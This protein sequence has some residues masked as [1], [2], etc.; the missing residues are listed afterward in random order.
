MLLH[1][2][3]FATIFCPSPTQAYTHTHVQSM[4]HYACVGGGCKNTKN[5][6][7]KDVFLIFDFDFEFAFEPF[8]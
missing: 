8:A 6:I 4:T 2:Q 5:E 7:H 1:Q 3:Q